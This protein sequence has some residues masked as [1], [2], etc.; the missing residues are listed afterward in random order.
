MIMSHLARGLGRRT[1]V[2]AHRSELLEQ[3]AN[4]MRAIW[5]EAIVGIFN[6]ASRDIDAQVCMATLHLAGVAEEPLAQHMLLKQLLK[7]HASLCHRWCTGGGCVRAD[8][9]EQE[10]S[11]AAS[12]AGV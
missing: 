6:A 8:G 7:P 1:L 11:G 2:L 5:P 9:Q 3:T 10:E 12:G 4:K